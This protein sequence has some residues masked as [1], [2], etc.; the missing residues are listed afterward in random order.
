MGLSSVKTLNE[1][2]KN[3]ETHELLQYLGHIPLDKQNRNSFSLAQKTNFWKITVRLYEKWRFRSASLLSKKVLD[4]EQE[5]AIM[6]EWIQLQPQDL[7][8]DVGSSTGLYARCLKQYADSN[9][10]PVQIA[11]T[12]ISPNFVRFANKQIDKEKL[13]DTRVYVMDTTQ[14]PFKNDTF[15]KIIIGGSFNEISHYEKAIQ[16][17][18]RV[19]KKGGLLFCMNLV[20][21]RKKTLLMR[22]L[23]LSGIHIHTPNEMKTFFHN[24]GFTQIQTQI[25]HHLQLALYQK[26]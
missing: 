26:S 12:D 17:W 25:H 6:Q 20:Y 4:F 9:H 3:P 24:A 11:G 5:C 16:E 15:D 10:I 23:A 8:L 21:S 18:C 14:L 19:L 7:I 1:L 13:S 2:L 22:L